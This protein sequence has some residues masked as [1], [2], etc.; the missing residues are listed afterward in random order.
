M[1][2]GSKFTFPKI[3]TWVVTTLGFIGTVISL[4]AYFAQDK[5]VDI[6]YEIIANTNVLDINADVSRLDITYN[7]MSL[8]EKDEHL[9][10]INLR[11]INRGIDNILKEYF[12]ENDPLGFKVSQ[13]KIIEKP[14]VIE[15]SSNYLKENLKV[16]MDSS[17]RV[18]FSKVIIEPKESVVL[19]ILIL[20]KSGT[21]PKIIPVGKIAGMK[22]ILVVNTLETKDEKPFFV[23]VF[24]GSTFVQI[25]RAISY[26]LMVVLLIV[27]I[28]FSADKIFDAK[29]KHKRKKIVD[30]YRSLKPY[31]YS[32]MD[33]AIFDHYIEN[34]Y[35]LLEKM[36]D[37]IND[38]KDL[39]AT[40]N[41]AIAR[42]KKK[43]E[44]KTV[45]HKIIDEQG[46][47]IHYIRED[48]WS[49][50]NTMLEYG[51]I[52]K[53][54]DRIVVNQQMK[55]TLD[56]FFIFLKDKKALKDYLGRIIAG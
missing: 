30:E 48:E 17:G 38:E 36:I 1:T 29:Q 5:K 33:D 16:E 15:T 12:D 24:F 35:R 22:E 8:K 26:F 4:Y 28:A 53:E 47:P 11:I 32:K 34:D 54:K 7:G 20:H 3:T 49:I 56:N 41:K 18:K 50:M 40:Y 13:G 51:L 37:L 45:D 42:L 43:E 10:I 19:K 55:N 39:T 21:Y 23:Q 9:R 27:V 52:I 46:Y 14:E 2:L 25:V 31:T 44:A 6:Q